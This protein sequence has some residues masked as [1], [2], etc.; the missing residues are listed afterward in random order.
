MLLRGR[1]V[2]VMP[3]D[4][5]G[6]KYCTLYVSEQ[7]DQ[8]PARVGTMQDIVGE[9]MALKWGQEVEMDV[10]NS[11]FEGKTSLRA[12]AIRLATAGPK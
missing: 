1:V 5:E 3:G 2:S 11:T 10:A 8:M 9:A 12:S 4:Y 7:L 6:K